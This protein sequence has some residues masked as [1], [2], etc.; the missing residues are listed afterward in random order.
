MCDFT[1]ILMFYFKVIYYPPLSLSHA[2]THERT[3]MHAFKP[4]TFWGQLKFQIFITCNNHLENCNCIITCIF[5]IFSMKT[6]ETIY[7]RRICKTTTRRLF[8]FRKTVYRQVLITEYSRKIMCSNLI[9]F[10]INS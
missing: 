5:F 9:L 7:V 3:H 6:K 8:V 2:R 10:Q 1:F 4:I